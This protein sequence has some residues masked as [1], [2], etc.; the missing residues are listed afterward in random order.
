MS[1]IILILL[2][3][4]FSLLGKTTV[5][6]S[7]GEYLL[8]SY[9]PQFNGFQEI[10]TKDGFI[11]F[12]PSVESA[13]SANELPG[14]PSRLIHSELIAIPDEDNFNVELIALPELNEVDALITPVIN[15][16]GNNEIEKEY[17][18]SNAYFSHKVENFIE[19]EFLGTSS[20]TKLLKISFN[21]AYFDNNKSSIILPQEFLV[22]VTY[23]NSQKYSNSNKQLDIRLNI[24][25]KQVAQNWLY[26]EKNN[27]S[28]KLLNDEKILEEKI[29]SDGKWFKIKVSKDG[30][31]NINLNQL[32]VNGINIPKDKINTIKIFGNGG[33]PLSELPTDGQNNQLNEQAIIVNKDGSGNLSNIVFFGSGT[34]GFEYDRNHF[35]RYTNWYS[36]D[37]YYLLTWGGSDGLRAEP[38][39]IIEPIQNTP[40]TYYH[41]LF[42]EEDLFNPYPVGGGRQF[43]GKSFTSLT[44]TNIL[45]N[46][47]RNGKIY[48]KV[49]VAHTSPESASIKITE[50]N[51]ELGPNL[52][53]GSNSG[54]YDVARGNWRTYTFD[55]QNI[56]SDNRSRLNFQYEGS[57]IRNA[58]MDYYE[59]HYPRSFVALNNE[60]YFWSDKELEGVTEFNVRGFTSNQKYVY[61]ITNLENPILL[62]NNASDL[63]KIIF[64]SKQTRNNPKRFFLTCQVININSIESIEF[65]D[66]RNNKFNNEVI[67]ITDE[68]HL[69]S[70]NEFKNYRENQS[71]ISTGVFTTQNI[72]NEFS[73]G[74]KDPTALRDFISNAYFNWETTP[75]YVV[76][77]GDGH[78][79]YKNITHNQPNYIFPY[80]SV[81]STNTYNEVFSTCFDDYYSRIDGNDPL[82]DLAIGRVTINSNQEG[83]DYVNKLRHYENN[84]STDNWRKRITLVADDSF[85][86][87]GR[88]E[89]SNH[90][91][92]SE[93]IANL[94]IMNNFITNKIYLPEFQTVFSAN[95]RNKPDA[96]REIIGSLRDD[97]SIIINYTGHGNPSVWAH[98]GVFTQ[99]QASRELN[100]LDKLAFFCAATCEYGR[101]DQTTGY[102]TAE[103][104][105]LSKRGGAI[106]ILAATRLVGV[107]ANDELNEL[108]FDIMLTK[109]NQNKY[110]NLGDV[111]YHLKQFRTGN[112][113]EK[114]IL[115]G[116]PTLKLLIPEYNVVFE[117]INDIQLNNNSDMIDLEG[118]TDITIKG[119]ITDE[120]YDIVSNFNGNVLFSIFDGDEE[121]NLTDGPKTFNFTKYG[122][123]LNKSSFEVSNGEFE[124]NIILPKDIS[125]SNRNGRM[126]AYA[127]NN[128]NS[129]TAKGTYN[130]FYVSGIGEGIDNNNKGPKISIYLDSRS[131]KNGDVVSN[132]PLLITDLEHDYGINSTGN[133]IGHKIEA[134]VNDNPRS[135]DLTQSYSTMIGNSRIGSSQAILNNVKP[136]LNKV[137]VRAW[138]IFNNFSIADAYFYIKGD[139][140]EL[141]V[142]DIKNYPNPFEYETNISFRHNLEIPF[143]A[144]IKIYNINGSLIRTLS[145]IKYNKFI[146][147]VKWDGKDEDGVPITNGSY[148]IQINL[149]DGNNQKITK[150]GILSLKLK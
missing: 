87:S 137:T 25:N 41:R 22:R 97:G 141:W 5:V 119:K 128:E 98:E 89:N 124:V 64:K 136:G 107:S 106:G 66:L 90:V 53:L 100:N 16:Y 145:E 110:D 7:T 103:E 143:D 34:K 9:K 27:K 131:F 68:A 86:S 17:R 149:K 40:T 91:N 115:L 58:Y 50:N 59:I 10:R 138:D 62:K 71:G 56:S 49:V 108:L 101:F 118:L 54:E 85:V 116:D 69:E 45:H 32:Q 120:N 61:D 96:N 24:L 148:Y 13:Y 117:Q 18:I 29:L 70:A 67:V 147:E 92:A 26:P 78:V 46:L 65:R 63:D 81:D 135:I 105:L 109:N 44:Q 21:V 113:D 94:S 35:K 80:L 23:N 150:S 4:T 99:S 142:G 130:Q 84:S 52:F 121:V 114:Y 43:L 33:K 77:W 72:Y 83:L 111:L 2:F 28:L 93:N 42:V 14:L 146:D 11:T 74:V 3:T 76:L 133:G 47:D 129:L 31:Y 123:I 60:L 144:D 38:Q 39:N 73:S 8:F 126:F 1:K 57:N 51:T 134:W 127:I 112:N 36:N 139:E 15:T 37:N 55:A 88:P 104:L 75:K 140:S 30:V 48:Y 102:T 125:Y 95:G 122:G 12:M 20:G 132:K 79:D 6:E 19:Y 82:V